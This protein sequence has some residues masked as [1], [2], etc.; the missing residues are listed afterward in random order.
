MG[1]LVDLGRFADAW[2]EANRVA[3]T[4]MVA[5][6]TGETGEAVEVSGGAVQLNLA[7]VIDA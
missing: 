7:P 6:L 1:R 3:H 5:V 4:Q 2:E